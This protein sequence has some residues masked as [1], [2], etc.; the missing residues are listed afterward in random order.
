M[1]SIIPQIVLP[2]LLKPFRASSLRHG[3]TV[4]C[5]L[6]IPA[7]GISDGVYADEVDSSEFTLEQEALAYLEQNPLGPLA[8]AAF[9]AAVEFQLAREY[10]EFA[11]ADSEESAPRSVETQALEGMH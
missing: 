2:E 4:V 9:I 8:E 6:A 5:I 3:L 10:P 11:Q 1:K 7:F